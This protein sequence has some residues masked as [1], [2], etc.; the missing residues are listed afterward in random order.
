MILYLEIY[1]VGVVICWLNLELIYCLN[2]VLKR[3]NC[4]DTKELGWMIVSWIIP[5][6]FIG[7]SIT[8]FIIYLIKKL[9][10]ASS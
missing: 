5:L 3:P 4:N 9:K 2:R 10:N 1:L 7:L 8:V 6:S